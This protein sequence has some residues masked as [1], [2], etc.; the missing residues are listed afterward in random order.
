MTF[1]RRSH[2]AI[3]LMSV[4]LV[5]IVVDS[6]DQGWTTLGGVGVACLVVAIT[7][8]FVALHQHRAA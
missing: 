1:A 7:A 2:I 8:Q 4:G 3:G 5:A 6:V